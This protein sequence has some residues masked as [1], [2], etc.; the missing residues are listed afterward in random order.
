MSTLS[1]YVIS[2]AYSFI[3]FLDTA[4][5]FQQKM[6]ATLSPFLLIEMFLVY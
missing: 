2:C 5:Y 6:S 4:A 3:Y 1:T